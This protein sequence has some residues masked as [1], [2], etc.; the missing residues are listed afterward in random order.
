MLEAHG[1]RKDY[2]DRQRFV[3]AVADVSFKVGTGEFVAVS[4]RSGSGKSTLLAML[5]GL[6][7]PSHGRV[8]V[9]G[10]D[11][12]SLGPREL[13]DFR[14]QRVGFVLQG[15]TLMPALRAVDN[16][17]LPALLART[18]DLTAAYACAETLL[19]EVGL[20]ER[21]DAYP[22][23]LS[24]G[25]Q[26]RVALARALVNRPPLIL[27]DEPT[28]DLDEETEAEVI[29]RLLALHRAQ[30]TTLVLVTHSSE[31]ARRA[32]R[33]VRLRG[34]RVEE[35]EDQPS[36]VAAWAPRPVAPSAS[37]EDAT[38]P[39]PLGAGLR[40]LV[41]N[42]V[43]WT[44]LVVAGVLALNLVVAGVRQLGATRK[45][46]ARNELQRAALQQL[47]ADLEDVA[48]ESDGGYRLTLFIE[49]LDPQRELFVLGP[50]VRV[51]IQADRGWK[52]V[53]SQST[54]AGE[55]GVVSVTGRRRF[56]FTF[57]PEVTTFE[58][59]IAGYYHVRITNA[60]LVSRRPRPGGDIVDRT[61]SY[62][63]Y[64]KPR[65][66]DDAE[67]RRRNGWG[68]GTPPVWIPMPAH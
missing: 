50:A 40:R 9:D 39:A 51:F 38:P 21:L 13:A 8:I 11:L 24:G 12:W 63:V 43:G 59:Q 16:V 41:W 44:T 62:Y 68:A 3:T 65:G 1:L 22:G 37:R 28:G 6:C 17:A 34:G 31:L 19:R 4:G 55:G 61:D 18:S 47:R 5:G 36:H 46:A 33:V 45:Q 20:A 52:E 56:A 64:V 42:F 35:G 60:M 48:Y 25:E 49:N 14:A 10:V 30:G 2:G 67:V 54:D 23:E 57:R 26:C 29:E 15:P 66:A 53:P 27:V 58:E 32:D 7:R